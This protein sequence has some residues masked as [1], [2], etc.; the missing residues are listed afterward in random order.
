MY[1]LRIAKKGKNPAYERQRDYM[2]LVID[3]GNTN[4]VFAV[5]SDDKLVGQWRMATDARRTADEYCVWLLQIMSYENIKPEK[6]KAAIMSS[7][8]PQANFALRMLA[9]QYFNTELLVVGEP[10]VQLGI[11]AKIE[12]PREVGADRLVNAVAAWQRH[13]KPLIIVDFGTATTFD[14]VD[15]GG[16]YIGGVIAPGVNLSLEALHRAAAKLPNIAVERPLNVIG[17][18]TVSA[19]QSGVYFGYVG[20]IEG[21]VR[22]I[23]EEYGSKMDVIA[24]GGLAPLFAKATPVIDALEPN[25]IIDGLR[26]IYERNLTK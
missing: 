18:D 6:I 25:L 13:K 26:L 7:V 17:K 12:R 4:T 2:L 10:N 23:T 11:L 15:N 3:A 1:L 21:I 16:D 20:L 24:T 14:V 19:M 5:F 9:R 22:R 8:V